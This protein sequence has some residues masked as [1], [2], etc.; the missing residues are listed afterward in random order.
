MNCSYNAA[1]ILVLIVGEL[2]QM[3]LVF[4]LFM[5]VLVLNQFSSYLFYLGFSDEE[6]KEY[7]GEFLVLYVFGR[8]QLI[9]MNSTC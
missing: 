2:F 5:K 8:I 4:S 9:L 7:F 3:T 1:E 6:A